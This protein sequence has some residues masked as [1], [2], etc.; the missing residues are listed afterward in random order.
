MAMAV[1]LKIK[2]KLI[3]R[4]KAGGMRNYYREKAGADE[5]LL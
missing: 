3:Y 2:Q 4:E 1:K 5:K